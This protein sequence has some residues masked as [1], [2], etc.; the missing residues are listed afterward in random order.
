MKVATTQVHGVL[1]A[2]HGI[3]LLLRGPSG[4]GK[5]GCALELIRR[6]HRLV[7]DD[8]VEVHGDPVNQRLVGA[9]PATIAGRLEVQDV[10]IIEVKPLFGAAALA[11]SHPIDAVVELAAATMGEHR[12]RHEPAPTTLLLGHT[13]RTY[14]IRGTEVISVANRLEV[15]ARMMRAARS[16]QGGT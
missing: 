9:P 1:V 16:D 6:G 11:A 8:V 5:S 4:T 7:A 14:A 10:G 12:R 15:I 13:L 2:V 3:G